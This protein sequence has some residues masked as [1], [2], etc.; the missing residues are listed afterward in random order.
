MSQQQETRRRHG[1]F[2]PVQTSELLAGDVF[3]DLTLAAIGG[4]VRLRATTELTGEPV[5]RR[6]AERLGLDDA[7]LDELAAA[8]VVTFDRTGYLAGGMSDTRYPS[9]SPA[10]VKLRQAAHR[11][12]VPVAD[13]RARLETPPLPSESESDQVVIRSEVTSDNDK[14]LV[15]EDDDDRQWLAYESTICSRCHQPGDDGNPL[16][17]GRHRFA[18]CRTAGAA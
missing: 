1:G 3:P 6:A 17:N 13:Y 10:E 4:W 11:A 8:G 12:G 15:T 9:E 5:A 18:D 16:T 2:V 14:S 7:V